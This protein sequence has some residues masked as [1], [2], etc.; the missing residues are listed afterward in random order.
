MNTSTRPAP[1]PD[2][3]TFLQLAAGTALAVGW[4]HPL[5]AAEP[6]MLEL[7][8]TH[9]HLWD[10]EKL[11][12][13]WL[14]GA[15][16]L[17]RNY[18]MSDYLAASQGQNVVQTVYMEV[19]VAP[20]QLLDEARYV[21][22]LCDRPD[23]PLRV[24]NRLF[25]GKER[26]V[27]LSAVYD[28]KGKSKARVRGLID[29]LGSYKFTIAENTPVEQEVALDPEL[30]GQVFE[31]LL[32]SYNPETET[33]A[34]KQTGS[35][36]TPR[37]I[38]SYMVDESLVAYLER[39]LRAAQRHCFQRRQ[40]IGGGVRRGS[41]ERRAQAVTLK[42]SVRLWPATHQRDPREQLHKFCGAPK[43]FG[44]AHQRMHADAG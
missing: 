15:Q 17:N 14:G 19:D 8:D 37:E 7:V 6:N 3:R 34:R 39:H 31:N 10:L 36:Y 25:F 5:A 29:I 38:V 22:A 35:F 30:L 12:L 2:R 23:N 42:R 16:E 41:V 24:P 28:N 33:T 21:L 20:E 32:A 11:R 26:E 44:F 27:D 13:P 43:L 4:S 18:V 40:Q 9:Q 1:L